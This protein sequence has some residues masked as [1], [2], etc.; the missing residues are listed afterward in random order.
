ML[1]VHIL[2]HKSGAS[3][4]KLTDMYCSL[5]LRTQ[6]LFTGQLLYSFCLLLG[7]SSYVFFYRRIFVTKSFKTATWVVL[8]FICAWFVGNV[9]QVFFICRPLAS[10]WDAS[11]PSICGNRPV[12]YTVMG[13]IN[14]ATDAVLM[15]LPV[16]YISKLQMSTS[17]KV[18]VSM[19]FLFG[20][21]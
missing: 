14:V 7:K 20:L 10:N 3:R 16:P 17:S 15:I 21:M 6:V 11:I 9:L 2:I 18:G 1:K 4:D 5:S 12:V 19:T 13:S 8:A